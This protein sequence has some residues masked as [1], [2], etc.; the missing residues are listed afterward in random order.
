[1]TT[2]NNL[3]KFPEQRT[4]FPEKTHSLYHFIRNTKFDIIQLE[5]KIKRM[6]EFNKNISN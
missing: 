4:L 6:I 1:M 5:M 3:E 2:Q